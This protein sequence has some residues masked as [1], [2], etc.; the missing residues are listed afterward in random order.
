MLFWTI[1]RVLQH[2]SGW[3]AA[4]NSCTCLA[5]SVRMC[6]LAL[7][8]G[9]TCH[10]CGFIAT[11][12]VS[13]TAKVGNVTVRM[14]PWRGCINTCRASCTNTSKCF[15]CGCGSVVGAE[16]STAGFNRLDIVH[17]LFRSVMCATLLAGSLVMYCT[18][19]AVVF[20]VLRLLI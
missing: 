20:S 1:T 8:A 16:E 11:W 3:Y 2:S 12:Q 5:D 17:K 13:H 4:A 18:A 14:F 15:C 10:D 19:S 9:A 6:M 7:S